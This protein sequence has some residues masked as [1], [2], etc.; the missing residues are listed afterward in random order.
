MAIFDLYLRP[1]L[2]SLSY[3]PDSPAAMP[4]MMAEDTIHGT[5]KRINKKL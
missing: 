5:E 1:H 4:V 3:E 2:A